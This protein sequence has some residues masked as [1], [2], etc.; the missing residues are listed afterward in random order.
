MNTENNQVDALHV[1]DDSMSFDEIQRKKPVGLSHGMKPLGQTNF[2][3]S[4]PPCH[5]ISTCGLKWNPRN[6]YMADFN[7]RLHPFNKW[8]KQIKQ[9]PEK[10]AS[11]GFYYH[12]L[13][14]YVDCFYCGLGVHEWEAYDNVN[15]EHCRHSP[16]CKYLD[17]V[18]DI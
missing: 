2:S 16:N 7:N 12:G 4:Q 8:P 1:M 15:F 6:I 10:L 3:S 17:I 11:L 14:D 13:G 5:Y 9:T 18:S